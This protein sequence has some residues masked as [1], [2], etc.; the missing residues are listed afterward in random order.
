MSRITEF[1]PIRTLSGASFDLLAMRSAAN[2]IGFED[3]EVVHINDGGRIEE[4]L[5]ATAAVLGVATRTST[6]I[7][8]IVPV[9]LFN[10][11]NVFEAP[12]DTAAEI[13]TTAE[14]IALLFDPPMDLVINSGV[15]Q[16]D[17]GAST[18]DLFTMVDFDISDTNRRRVHIMGGFA[19]QMNQPI[20]LN[21]GIVRAAAS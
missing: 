10:M 15:H 12:N 16:V 14:C 1:G 17:T 13:D 9:W 4:S 3:G 5:A 8:T 7:E 18:I 2:N 6:A 21:T 19:C 11:N 20:R